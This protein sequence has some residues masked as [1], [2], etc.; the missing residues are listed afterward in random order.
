[1]L[2]DRRQHLTRRAPRA[3]E[4]SALGPRLHDHHRDVVGARV[5][6]LARDLR[7]LLD[8][9]LA[10][11]DVALTLRDLRSAL[12]VAEDPAHQEHHDQRDRR[13][14]H[15]AARPESECGRHVRGR[16][17]DD[18]P[19]DEERPARPR[20]QRVHRAH[21]GDAVAH[22]RRRHPD[23]GDDVPDESGSDPRQARGEA[24]DGDE[25]CEHD[26]PRSDRHSVVVRDR[27]AAEPDLEL[28]DDGE[29]GGEHPI[30]L[31]RVGTKPEQTH[32][33]TVD[34]GRSCVISLS[35]DQRPPKDRPTGRSENRPGRRRRERP[36]PLR[37]IRSANRPRRIAMRELWDRWAP[38]AG[39]LS[40]ACSFVGVMLVLNQPQDKDSDAKIVAYFAEHSHRVEGVVGFFVFLAGLLLLVAFLAALRERLLAADGG[41]SRSTALA[42]GAG[43][44][45]LPLWAMSTLLANATGFAANE[46]SRFRVDPNTFRLLGD[47]AYFAWVA[48]VVVSALVV[49]GTS[50][51]AL[52]TGLLPGWYARLGILTGVVQLFGFFFFPFFVWWLWLIVTSVL[53]VVR[54]GPARVAV[55][56]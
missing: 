32:G 23:P 47:T 25:R 24:A 2:L 20:R 11:G 14:L 1:D 13:E 10:R 17:E 21:P 31:Q 8:D 16:G 15:F 27:A 12:A 42:F 40:V 29:P 22:A 46:T 56:Q 41:S 48:A 7:S 28:A 6:Q 19:G 55:P 38:L 4:D 50:A 5:V 53:L 45:S 49:W 3:V 52:R 35:A 33:S 34:A 18:D 51:V 37:S 9:R 43:V 36:G 54:R 39:V 26:H 30:D 44:A